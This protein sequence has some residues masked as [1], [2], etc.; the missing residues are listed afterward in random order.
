MFTEQLSM[1]WAIFQLSI[2][3]F[4]NLQSLGHSNVSLK[5]N[6]IEPVQFIW[7]IL[8]ARDKL[9]KYFK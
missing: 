6:C 7:A 9:Y 5:D 2:P 8:C 4:I 3:S 1:L